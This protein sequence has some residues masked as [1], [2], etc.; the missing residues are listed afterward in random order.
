MYKLFVY[1]TL[2]EGFRLHGMLREAEFLGTYKTDP[3]FVLLN[4][5]PYPALARREPGIKVTG[6]VYD[7]DTDTIN[8]IDV[9]EGVHRGQYTREEI[10]VHDQIGERIKAFA[11]IAGRGILSFAKT[12]IPTGVWV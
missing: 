10:E 11:Y 6:E 4:L 2:K 12:E 8:Y 7:L 1:G 5:G 3:K 9:V